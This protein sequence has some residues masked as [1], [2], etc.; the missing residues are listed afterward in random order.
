MSFPSLCGSY[1]AFHQ[2]LHTESELPDGAP[3]DT[4]AGTGTGVLTLLA[5][6]GITGPFGA[7]AAL[8]MRKANCPSVAGTIWNPPYT[9]VASEGKLAGEDAPLHAF[10][11]STGGELGICTM[12]WPKDGCVG[13]AAGGIWCW[14]WL[15]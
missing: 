4:A 9:L 1:S 6:T 3:G 15:G 12:D 10:M 11:G 7:N 8:G 5:Y 2:G 14:C 13:P